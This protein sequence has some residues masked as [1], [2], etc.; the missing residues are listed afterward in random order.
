MRAN[1]AAHAPSTHFINKRDRRVKSETKEKLSRRVNQC[2]VSG[3]IVKLPRVKEMPTFS[4][5]RDPVQNCVKLV[6]KY[7]STR[8]YILRLIYAR[9]ATKEITGNKRD[10]LSLRLTLNRSKYFILFELI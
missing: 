7:F 3:P 5:R 8:E 6:R 2:L 4:Q 10:F 1:E 9:P